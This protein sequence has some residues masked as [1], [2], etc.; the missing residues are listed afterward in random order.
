MYGRVGRLIANPFVSASS[1]CS[2]RL[3]NSTR[4][5]AR[6]ACSRNRTQGASMSEQHIQGLV[7]SYLRDFITNDYSRS[8]NSYL[9]HLYY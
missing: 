3:G 1:K 6:L 5:A 2:S 8:N 9:Q 7:A 4:S